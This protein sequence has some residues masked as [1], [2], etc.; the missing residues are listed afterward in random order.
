[1]KKLNLLWLIAITIISAL[2]SCS[3]MPAQKPVD[4]NGDDKE[5]LQRWYGF[6]DNADYIAVMGDVQEYVRVAD[7]L[8]YFEQTMEWLKYQADA[9]ANIKAMAFV[10]DLTDGNDDVSQWMNYQRISSIATMSIPTV[11]VS[12]NHDFDWERSASHYTAIRDRASCHLT[13][14]ANTRLLSEHIVSSFRPDSI[15]NIVFRNE[16][17]GKRIDIIAL[18]FGTRPE[19]LDW[20]VDYVEAHP[21]HRFIVLTHELLLSDGKFCVSPWTFAD[22]QFGVYNIPYST[23]E[24]VWS[25]LV[26]PHNNVI[27][28]LCGHNGFS[29]MNDYE[30]VNDTGR[31]VPIVLFNLQYQEN[32]GDGLVAIWEFPHGI[33]QVNIRI[34]DTKT[35]TFLEGENTSFTFTY[36]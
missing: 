25:R 5:E 3:D 32:G 6:A 12:G 30:K 20:A 9:G 14:F 1:M 7:N 17:D 35:S 36:P 15:D 16:I 4:D 23:P 33:N 24:E 31:K 26:K 29:R 11:V 18:E 2:A 10:G 19:V 27:A 22:Q 13:Q 8:P 28:M 34:I 21:Q